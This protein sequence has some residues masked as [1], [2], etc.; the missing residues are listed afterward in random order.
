M[1]RIDPLEGARKPGG[2]LFSV[3]YAVGWQTGKQADMQPKKLVPFSGSSSSRKK[4]GRTSLSSA[5]R[6]VPV[7]WFTGK[8]KGFVSGMPSSNP[9]GDKKAQGQISLKLFLNVS[10]LED[11]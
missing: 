4:I 11:F 2:S 10:L 1:P 6:R 8:I 3:F 5:V 9:W 7:T